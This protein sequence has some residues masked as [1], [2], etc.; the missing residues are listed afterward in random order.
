[1]LI[2]VSPLLIALLAAVFLREPFT[3]FLGVGLVLAFAGVVV[4]APVHL[5]RR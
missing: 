5:L 1:M 2:Q 4:I 3:R